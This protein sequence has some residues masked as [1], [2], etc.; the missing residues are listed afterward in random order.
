MNTILVST[1]DSIARWGKGGVPVE[2]EPER[3]SGILSDPA[4]SLNKVGS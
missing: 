4:M 3:P 1:I 2:N